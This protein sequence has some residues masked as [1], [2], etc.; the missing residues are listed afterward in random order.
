MD[1]LPPSQPP[2]PGLILTGGGAR[3]A[4]QVG[5]LKAVAELLPH[6]ANPFRVIV[7][8]S[9]GA[10]AAA[11]LA[12]RA[13]RWHEAVA[14][15]E[16]VWANFRTGQV[17]DV[18]RRSM[19][20]SGLQWIL[21]LV[22]GGLLVRA[23]SSLFDNAPLRQ[24]LKGE[25]RWR[26]VGRSVRHGWLDALA[27]CS[28][29]YVTARSVAF[30]EGR[31]GLSE[32]SGYNHVGRRARLTHS[33]L[34]ASMA[35]PLMFP[36]EQ[37]D[38]AYYG[39]G[40]VRQMAPLAPALQL[41]ANRLLIIGMRDV[42]GGGVS[43]RRSTPRAAPTPGQLAG[44]ALDNL[45]T[46]QIYNDLA[47]IEL[48]NQILRLQPTALPGSHV[49]EQVVFLTPS[50]DPRELAAE[51]LASLPRSLKALLR[52]GGASSTAGAQLASYLMFE[53]EYTRSLIA[54]GRS[55]ALARAADIRQLLAPGQS[56]DPASPVQPALPAGAAPPQ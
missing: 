11:V 17:F 52:V 34:M 28:T 38:E 23:P 3:A 50:R 31:E 33:H 45:F 30:F 48:V 24:L 51:H 2:V 44:F 40:A 7:G 15:I 5:V 1:T 16:H 13:E 53:G 55:D 12:A 8:T 35:V 14:A 10:V 18:R 19:L 27:L 20:R 36:P 25:V 6:Q 4:Y 32:W 21:S 56:L 26:G 29:E 42:R 43:E 22:S 41:G 46:D 37:I 54:L 47:Q 49:V 39:D 9:A